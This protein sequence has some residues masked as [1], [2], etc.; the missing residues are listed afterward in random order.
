MI[1]IYTDWATCWHNGKLGTVTKVW[2]WVYIKT[3]TQ[4]IKYCKSMPGI[5]NNEAEFKAVIEALKIAH[6]R[7]FKVITICSDSK[8]VINR[9]HGKRPANKK[10]ENKRMDAFQEEVLSLCTKLNQVTF[11]WIPRELN[12]EADALSKEGS[13]YPIGFTKLKT[14]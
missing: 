11:T 7:D 12:T 6:T 9:C 5:S 14:E 1:T 2:I 13:Y 8:I 10:Y 3:D 4:V